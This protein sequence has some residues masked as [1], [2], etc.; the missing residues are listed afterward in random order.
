[1]RVIDYCRNNGLA[2]ALKPGPGWYYVGNGFYE[3]S[4]WTVSALDANGVVWVAAPTGFNLHKCEAYAV[5][6]GGLSQGLGLLEV[7][8]AT[9]MK[10]ILQ[11][12][13]AT[14]G[15]VHKSTVELQN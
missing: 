2:D 9:L 11:G 13:D 6:G 14:R 15:I 12:G 1:K 5:G 8:S 3:Q 4:T 7:P 10:F